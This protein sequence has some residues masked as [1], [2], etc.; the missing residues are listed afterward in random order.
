MSFFDD[1]DKKLKESEARWKQIDELVEATK[2]IS[3]GG[4]G[5]TDSER[6]GF[7]CLVKL[8]QLLIEEL[9]PI[10]NVSAQ[11]KEIQDDIMNMLNV[12]E[13]KK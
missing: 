12:L 9:R 7:I 2:H 6:Q 8:V 3:H 1:I 11:A 4:S 5:L 13:V 10:G